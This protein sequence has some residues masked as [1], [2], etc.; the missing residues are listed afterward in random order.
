MGVDG[1]LCI[2][3]VVEDHEPLTK[4]ISDQVGLRSGVNR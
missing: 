2:T 3:G 1:L 4:Q